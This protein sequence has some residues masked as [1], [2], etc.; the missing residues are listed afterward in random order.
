MQ[1]QLLFP[2]QAVFA[3]LDSKEKALVQKFATNMLHVL[4]EHLSGHFLPVPN[5][6]YRHCNV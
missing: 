6:R 4:Q 5:R 1:Q 3:C 2:A